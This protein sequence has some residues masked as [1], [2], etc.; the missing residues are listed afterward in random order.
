MA[1]LSG[2]IDYFTFGID[3]DAHTFKVAGF[4]AEESMSRLFRYTVELA[5]ED[6]DL[7]IGD[8]VG[9]AAHLKLL[10]DDGDV[11]RHV[12]GFI[13]RMDQGD[14]GKRFT[15][16]YVDLRPKVYWLT[17]RVN[18]RIFQNV[19]VVDIVKKVL[20]DNKISADLYKVACN[21]THEARE[22]CVQYRETDLDF[23]ERLMAEEG[24]F[25]FFEHSED[26]HVM[27]IADHE[28][29]HGAIGGEAS[30]IFHPPTG[31]QSASDS[32]SRFTWSERVRS[33]KVT[34]RDYAFKKPSLNLEAAE[35]YSADKELE[36]YD[37]GA[38]YEDPALG[39]TRAKMRLQA[40]QVARKTGKGQSDCMRLVSGFRFT[41]A[42]HPSDA[43]NQ[44]YVITSVRH[45][46]RQ[47]QVL[48][49][50]AG[51]E[52]SR[53]EN[54]FSVIPAS[55][56]YRA[57][58]VTEKP[59]MRGMQTAVVTGPA[60][61]EIYT[62]E[63]GRVK[64]QFHWDRE[65]KN[66]DKSA[67]WMR[68]T[69]LWAG[70]GWGAMFLPRVGHEVLVDFIEGDP[71]RPV[72]VGRVY[73]GTN[74]PPYKLPDEKT[75]SAIRS[76]TSPNANTFN[77]LLMEDKQG[78][79]QVVLSNAYGHKI[80][81]DEETQALTIQT[82]DSNMVK[83]DDKEKSITVSTTDGHKA[84]FDDT[85]KKIEITSKD[86]QTISLVDN[87]ENILTLKTKMGNQF[88]LSDKD[89]AISLVTPSGHTFIV[90]DKDKVVSLTTSGANTL[91]LSDQDKLI[92]IEDGDGK[93]LLKFDANGGKIEL[94]NSGGD[95]KLSAPS[96]KIALEAMSIEMKADAELK[97]EG[98]NVTIEG[99]AQA[100]FK[101]AMATTEGSGVMTVKGGV[102][103]I[104]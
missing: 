57:P 26:K 56:P 77:E 76:N 23:I 38:R 14:S 17:Q 35:E 30:V 53:Y 27:V 41:L 12:H 89:E 34:L 49:E 55:V 103:M 21:Q 63:F 75:K 4:E 62:D 100:T 46:A 90:S 69:Q 39:K 88:Q 43:F 44:E 42:E 50:G 37:Y 59:V 60:G 31:T 64:V 32:V 92:K 15:T 86:G 51:D 71:D 91:T 96:G 20:A 66:D 65:G 95:I 67:C 47:P 97:A 6:A 78:K 68:V 61:E 82:R 3:G 84:L 5:C 99:K 36:L 93:M 1:R 48:E 7:K 74:R 22:Y 25:Y 70:A 54:R 81:E 9:K 29:A 45:E 72:V 10:G 73:H 16:Y 2:N 19:S 79:T 18:C 98:A 52:G 83:L 101:G 8:L 104:N 13:C 80:I 94:S 28:S 33:G 40:Q 87:E 24:I 85:N 58:V 102:V 11:E